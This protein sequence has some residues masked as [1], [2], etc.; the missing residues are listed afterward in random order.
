MWAGTLRTAETYRKLDATS[1]DVRHLQRL[2]ALATA[3]TRPAAAALA[4][5]SVE[6][7]REIV[8]WA[9]RRGLWRRGDQRGMPG[10]IT[11]KGIAALDTA[12]L[13]VAA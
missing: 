6:T 7:I 1:L 4:G 8:D 9:V 5:V 12:G 11:D 13:A 2:A 3:G 10:S